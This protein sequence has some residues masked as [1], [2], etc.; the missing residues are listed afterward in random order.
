FSLLHDS[1]SVMCGA[2]L[3]FLNLGTLEK[4]GAGNGVSGVG[5][6][7]SRIDV[8]LINHS[9]T[10]ASAGTLDIHGGGITASSLDVA[11]GALLRLSLDYTLD[12]ATLKIVGTHVGSPGTRPLSNHVMATVA[13]FLHSGGTLG[14]MGRASWRGLG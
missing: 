2:D 8:P 10:R 3:A 6:G 14:E 12:G 4:S 7:V 9:V 1:S 11:A 13:T 5:A